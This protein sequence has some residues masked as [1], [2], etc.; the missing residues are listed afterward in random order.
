MKAQLMAFILAA[1]VVPERRSAPMR[2]LRGTSAA[3]LLMRAFHRCVAAVVVIGC[4]LAAQISAAQGTD[5]VFD[6]KGFTQNRDYFS[7]SPTE[8]I[9]TLTGNPILTYT[10]LV[11]PGN[12]GQSVQFQRTFN[13]KSAAGGSRF[14]YAGA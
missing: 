7:A 5:P 8:H 3:S 14:W 11:L 4:L 2:L 6:S 12:A 13:P 10:D 1:V 9:D